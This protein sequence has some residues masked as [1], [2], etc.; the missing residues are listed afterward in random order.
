[1]GFFAYF[2]AECNPCEACNPFRSAMCSTRTKRDTPE[3]T[4]IKF[5]IHGKYNYDVHANMKNA[6]KLAYKYHH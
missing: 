5:K 1:M 6:M 2:S 4:S 3:M